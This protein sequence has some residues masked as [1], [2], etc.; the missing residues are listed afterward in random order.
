MKPTL[1][2]CLVLL[3]AALAVARQADAPQ[4]VDAA[5]VIDSGPV[6]LPPGAMPIEAEG[7]VAVSP[8]GEAAE[9]SQPDESASTTSSANEFQKNGR[10]SEKR[11]SEGRSQR[12]N[13]F[14]RNR[15]RFGS[16]RENSGAA[17]DSGTNGPSSLDFAAF[18]V[19]AE[20]NIF[21]PNRTPVGPAPVR[22]P[23]S[24]YFSLVGTARYG[25]GE[26]PG[27]YAIFSGSDSKYERR[28][29]V[30]DSIAGYKLK[31]IGFDSVKLAGATNE[32]VMRMSAQLRREENGPWH[33]STESSG[34]AA[35]SFRSSSSTSE[36]SSTSSTN[37]TAT[38]TAGGGAE[39]EVLKRL[40]QRRERE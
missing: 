6:A 33:L 26:F 28:L 8:G 4:P 7:P 37:R 35:G 40:M 27:T 22:P 5:P 10:R 15:Q 31:T 16:S 25:K 21:D 1:I 32:V 24:E 2:F 23:A 36:S 12:S 11:R 30:S 13:R 39:D 3:G 14:G 19:I 29:K 17:T 9:P 38:A 34:E 18:K 20:L